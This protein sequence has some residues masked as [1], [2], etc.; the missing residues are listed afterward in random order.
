MDTLIVAAVYASAL[1][2]ARLAYLWFVYKVAHDPSL[3]E[4]DRKFIAELLAK[5]RSST[6]EAVA[7]AI[8]EVFKFL[9][10]QVTGSR[11]QESGSGKDPS[12]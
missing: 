10:R 9:R 7:N 4:T 5:I 8:A 2:L 1:L 6:I 3:N 11:N 12:A